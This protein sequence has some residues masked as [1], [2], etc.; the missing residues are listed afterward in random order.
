M[1][2]LQWGVIIPLINFV[3]LVLFWWWVERRWREN[4]AKNSDW[5]KTRT[6]ETSSSKETMVQGHKNQEAPRSDPS[7]QTDQTDPSDRTERS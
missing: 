1:S 2:W 5:V 6:T 7:D 3:L 4:D